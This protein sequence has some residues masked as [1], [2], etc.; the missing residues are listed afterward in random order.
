MVDEKG[1]EDGRF[2][3]VSNVIIIKMGEKRHICDNPFT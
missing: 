3:Y 1:R 2:G